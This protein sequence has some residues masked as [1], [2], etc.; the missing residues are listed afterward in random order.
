MAVPKPY[1][2]KEE[3][4]RRGTALYEQQVRPQV[5][6]GNEGKVVG[7]R[8]MRGHE[9]RVEVEVGGAITSQKLP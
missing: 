2:R 9:L 3:F 7:M 8:L 5:E 1:S 4:V 6:S